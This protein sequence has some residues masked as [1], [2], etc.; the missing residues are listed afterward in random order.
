[1]N[2]DKMK[3]TYFTETREVLGEMEHLLLEI[4]KAPE[5][6]EL[7]NALFRAVHT[8]KGSSGMFGVRSVESFTHVAENVLDRVRKRR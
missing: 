4:E 5:D 1:M 7:V 2:L 6:E 3:Q 8:I